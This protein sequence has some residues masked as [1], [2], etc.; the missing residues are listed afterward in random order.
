M[1][2]D[3]KREFAAWKFRTIDLL[4]V[5]LGHREARVAICLLGHINRVTRLVNPSQRRVAILLDMDESAV[6]RAIKKLV[7]IGLL[8][9]ERAN[10]QRSNHYAF[11]ASKLNEFYDL[12][13]DREELARVSD[14]EEVSAQICSDGEETPGRDEEETPSPD[15]EE[16]SPKLLKG[17][18]EGNHEDS[19]G[20]KGGEV[21]SQEVGLGA[22]AAPKASAPRQDRFTTP[23]V[24]SE[25]LRASAVMQKRD[26]IDSLNAQFGTLEPLDQ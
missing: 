17:T 11:S 7:E 14:R 19:A 21:L 20:I 22:S 15:R 1:E 24:I 6:R 12:R 13:R 8:E 25:S 3:D 10:R 16:V 4:N 2:E 23:V 9:V 26:P 5:G 18:I